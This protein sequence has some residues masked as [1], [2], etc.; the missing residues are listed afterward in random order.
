MPSKQKRT[1]GVSPRSHHPSQ[2]S[3]D[4]P[5]V[6][7]AQVKA[8]QD[9]RCWL[10]DQKAYKRFRPLQIC[11]IFPQAISKRFKFVKHHKSSRTQLDNIHNVR[12]LVAL[13]SI[14]HLAFD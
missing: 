8:S 10:C 1:S 11:H 2:S 9:N 3:I 7:K 4:V 13:C 14:C 6:V 5:T 12:N